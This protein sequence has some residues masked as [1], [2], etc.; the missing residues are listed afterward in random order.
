MSYFVALAPDAEVLAPPLPDDFQHMVGHT[1]LWHEDVLNE[2]GSKFVPAAGGTLVL[3]TGVRW[4]RNADNRIEHGWIQF[5]M[6]RMD[7]T[8]KWTE[9]FRIVI[10][11]DRL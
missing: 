3:I 7:G 4:A 11:E 10:E 9:P 5:F 1:V 2:D 6:D 8:Q